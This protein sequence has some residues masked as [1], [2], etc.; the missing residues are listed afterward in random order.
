MKKLIGI[1]LILSLMLPLFA[2]A[3]GPDLVAGI[4]ESFTAEDSAY[5]QNKHGMQGYFRD[6]AFEETL[7]GDSF[8]ITI[9][10]T[11]Y[12]DGS[13]TFTRDGDYLTLT[14]PI[15]DFNATGMALYLMKA[16]GAYYS[17]NPDLV[18]GYV[19]ALNMLGL[20]NR[21]F[22]QTP[23]P[24]GFEYRVYIGGPYEMEELDRM[25]PEEDFFWRAGWMPLEDFN[26]SMDISFG[27]TVLAVN[28]SRSSCTLV[29]AEFGELDDI[30]FSTLK[31]AVSCLQPDG[32]EA[33]LADYTEL[34][35]AELPGCTVDL[36]PDPED[37]L[38]FLDKL[39]EGYSCMLVTFGNN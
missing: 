14:A 7:D 39:P 34:K 26:V 28:G 8:T 2:F 1:M 17:Q 9:S 4:F 31:G 18:N 38:R 5:S 13:W 27:K 33:F 15:E 3:E 12:Q 19:T 11:D 29:I 35:D 36:N 22:K 6:S 16:V 24:Q 23:V 37:V 25:I 30:A 20:E 10:G 32:G 21:Y